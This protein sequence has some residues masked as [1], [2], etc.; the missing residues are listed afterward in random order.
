MRIA[1]AVLR[2][3]AQVEVAERDPA[4]LTRPPRVDDLGRQR[5]QLPAE[6]RDR[7]RGRLLLEAGPEREAACG[8]LEHRLPFGVGSFRSGSFERSSVPPADQ[9]ITVRG[10][11]TAT[12]CA[13]RRYA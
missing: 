11:P 2:V 5:E 10:W 12:P 6:G 7:L 8:D 13:A 4:G 1:G 9:G 3:E